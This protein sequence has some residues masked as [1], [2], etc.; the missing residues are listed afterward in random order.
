VIDPTHH[1]AAAVSKPHSSY[2]GTIEVN[3]TSAF[4][5]GTVVAVNRLC[6]RAAAGRKN[7]G[8]MMMLL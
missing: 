6:P 4:G 5:I 3:M 8:L 1:R 7:S 2:A